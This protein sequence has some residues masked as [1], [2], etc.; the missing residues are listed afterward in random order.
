MLPDPFVRHITGS[1]SPWKVC[2]SF[3]ID[4]TPVQAFYLFNGK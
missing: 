1:V 2:L 4:K 3:T